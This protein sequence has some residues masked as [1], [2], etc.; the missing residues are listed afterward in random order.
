MEFRYAFSEW[1]LRFGLL[2][3]KIRSGVPMR[4]LA[5][6]KDGIELPRPIG[7]T[8]WSSS[9]AL[10]AALA[11]DPQ[12]VAGKRVLELGCGSGLCGVVA[13]R[14]GAH[15]TATDLHPDMQAL[16]AFNAQL[17]GV[18]VSYTSYPWYSEVTPGLF[19]VVIGSD[20]LYLPEQCAL[21]L[22]ALTRTLLP[23]GCAL[24]ADPGRKHLQQFETLA[25]ERGFACEWTQRSLDDVTHPS[26]DG[27]LRLHPGANGPFHL[28]TLR[29]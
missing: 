28:F 14:L 20:V 17:N 2:D 1:D 15:V 21:V 24:I 3:V 4:A 27:E 5:P 7:A 26:G 10:A 13:A 22:D 11:A 16:L 19:D 8:V 29:R 6:P 23:H 12:L 25:R 18:E 9:L